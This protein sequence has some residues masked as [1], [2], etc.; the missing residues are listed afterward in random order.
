MT[1][2]IITIFFNFY[3]NRF[4]GLIFENIK[5]QKK[6]LDFLSSK[7]IYY[8]LYRSILIQIISIMLLKLEKEEIKIKNKIEL[9][10]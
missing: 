7:K 2:Y 6:L 10:D 3:Q 1:Y 8:T 5:V 9:S 4:K